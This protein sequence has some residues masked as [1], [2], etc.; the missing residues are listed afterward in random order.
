MKQIQEFP[1]FVRQLPEL[2][3][4]IP[5]ARGWLLQGESN[6]IAFAEFS[7]QVEVPEHTHAEQ[8]EFAIAGKV[9]LHR[10]GKSTEYGPGESFFL[11]ALEPH[12][13]TVQ[14]GYKAMIIFNEAERYRAKPLGG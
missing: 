11:A 7:E 3:L 14:A 1:D 2:D 5:G 12:G 8:W 4:P 10:G 6:Q 13:A 9:T